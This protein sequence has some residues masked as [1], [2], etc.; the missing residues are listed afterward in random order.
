MQTVLPEGFPFFSVKTKLFLVLN[1]TRAN[2][3]F[4]MLAT[5][6][7]SCNLIIVSQCVSV[8]CSVFVYM[9]SLRKSIDGIM[10]GL[11][12]TQEIEGFSSRTC[13]H[14]CALWKGINV[15]YCI[16]KYFLCFYLIQYIYVNYYLNTFMD[17][18]IP[19][20]KPIIKSTTTKACMDWFN[21]FV[22]LCVRG[23]GGGV[24]MHLS[25]PWKPILANN[26]KTRLFRVFTF[27]GTKIAFDKPT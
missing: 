8:M 9:I 22:D 14:L 3:M 2:D 17:I 19:S 7:L 21:L 6:W 12:V 11:L 16:L 27:V 5:C 26:T 23:G 20:L 25:E 13:T 4:V 15:N 10:Y 1:F 18:R 24:I